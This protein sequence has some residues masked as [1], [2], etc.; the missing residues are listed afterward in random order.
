MRGTGRPVTRRSLMKTGGALGAL[1]VAGGTAAAATPLFGEVPPA[2]AAPEERIVWSHCGINCGSSCCHQY[3]VT[4]GTIA[5]MESD[6]TGSSD[7]DA[8]QM[9]ACLRGRSARRWLQGEGRLDYPLKRVGRR[10]EGTFERIGW[11]EALD[12]I[13]GELKRVYAEYGPEA[14]YWHHGTGV[15]NS[16]IGDHAI[17]RL[18]GLTGGFLGLYGDYSFAQ[19]YQSSLHTYGEEDCFGGSFEHLQDGQLVVFFAYSPADTRMGGGAHGHRLQRQ[20][21]QKNVRIVSID[22]RRN[23][24]LCNWG[25]EWIPIRPGTDGALASALAYEFV[26]NGWTDDEFLRTRCVGFDEDTLPE[27]VKGKN[28]S[29]KDYLLGTGYDR[30]AKTP[31]WA[32][33]ITLIPEERIKRLAREMAEAKPVFIA[34]GAGIQRRSNGEMATRCIMALPQLLGQ[35]GKPGTNDGRMPS[36]ST[37][38]MP[39]MEH[40]NPCETAISFFT[41][42]QAIVDGPSMTATNAGVRGAER[43]STSIKF[44][45][46]YACNALTNQHGDINRMHEILADE[47]LCEFIVGYDVYLTDSNKYADILLP[48]LTVQEQ[49]H[50]TTNGYADPTPAVYFG[51]PVYEPKGERR[52]VYDVCCDLARRMGV[53]DAFSDG[54]KTQ[55][56]WLRAFYEEYRGYTPGAPTWDEGFEQGLYKDEPQSVVYWE[57]FVNDPEGCPLATPSGKIEIYSETLAEYA[58]TWELEEGQVIYPIPAYDPGARS[59]LDC[60]EEFPLLVSAFHYKAHTHSGYAMNKILEDAAPC[61]LWM[62]PAD[63]EPRGIADG[64]EVRVFNEY[65]EVRKRVRVTERIVPGVVSMPTGSMHEADMFG[66]KVDFGGCINTLTSMQPSP[67]AKANGTHSNIGQVEKVEVGE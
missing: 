56:D 17:M 3:H 29:Y 62:N 32:S 60:T 54:G 20:L 48:D 42:P 53:Y 28:A 26:R 12:T 41:F 66:D 2:C 4:D 21:E 39:F 14:V 10:G 65:G 33:E 64:D 52:G 40:E 1:A 24:T 47:S 6:N 5:Y 34:Q 38:F 67:L 61:W 35:M 46:N 58:D 8:V 30:V 31:A 9:R 51:Q 18:L 45:F 57:D 16:Q 49:L 27:S 25:G 59:Y 13:A 36:L 15:Y 50:V 11:D 55:E 7:F 44:L 43:V 23:D 37:N 22:Y 19:F 63:A